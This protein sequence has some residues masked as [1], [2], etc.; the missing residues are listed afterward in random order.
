MPGG[1]G[2]DDCGTRFFHASNSE[3][4]SVVCWSV[5]FLFFS[6]KIYNSKYEKPIEEKAV[7][8]GFPPN[9]RNLDC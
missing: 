3:N 2:V 8:D 6:V 1:A 5:L 7:A 4:G 9:F